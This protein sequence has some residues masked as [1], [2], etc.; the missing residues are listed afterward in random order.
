MSQHTRDSLV[1][2]PGF[3]VEKRGDVEVKVNSKMLYLNSL[4]YLFYLPKR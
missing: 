2:T 3:I 1:E 4:M